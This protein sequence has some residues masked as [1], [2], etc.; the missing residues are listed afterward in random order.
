MLCNDHCWFERI[1]TTPEQ[2]L[3]PGSLMT[4]KSA[5]PECLELLAKGQSGSTGKRVPSGAWTQ[6]Q[7]V[8]A[9]T[10][11]N[12]PRHGAE[13]GLQGRRPH[14]TSDGRAKQAPRAVPSGP[15]PKIPGQSAEAQR[16]WCRRKTQGKIL[17]RMPPKRALGERFTP[18]HK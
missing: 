12:Q 6:G 13:L 3:A 17:Q 16:R 1:Q 15:H 18:T 9:S 14:S 10:M 8:Q 2:K 7:Q 11:Q 5:V 4:E